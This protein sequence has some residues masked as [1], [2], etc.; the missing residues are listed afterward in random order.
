[1]QSAPGRVEEPAHNHNNRLLKTRG[2]TQI[3]DHI[4]IDQILRFILSEY[5]QPHPLN[6]SSAAFS[7]KAPV[8]KFIH[9]TSA[10]LPAT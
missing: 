1:M 9:G 10:V 6:R 5:R 8:L 3:Q 4:S 2:T 7:R